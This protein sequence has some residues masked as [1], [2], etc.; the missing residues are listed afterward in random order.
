MAEVDTM[1]DYIRKHKEVRDVIISGGDCLTLATSRLEEV[2]SKIRRIGH[3]EIIRI[4]TRF[5][6]VL[7]QRI[8]DE[9]CNMLSK[10]GRSGLTP[11]STIR[12]R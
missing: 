8:D 12:E 11:T 6:V 7:P 4:G 5:P 1:L 9:L 3:V 2:I 10:Y